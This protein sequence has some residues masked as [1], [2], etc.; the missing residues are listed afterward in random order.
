MLIV[1][2][3]CYGIVHQKFIPGIMHHEFVPEGQDCQHSFLHGGFEAS[4]GSCAA[5]FARGQQ[6]DPSPG[7]C[8]FTHCLDS[9]RVFGSQLNHC[10][11]PPSLLAEFS[12]LRFF[13][14]SKVQVDAAWAASG[15]CGNDYSQ[16]GNVAQ[17][18]EGRRLSRV[19]QPMETE[20]GQ[21][22]CI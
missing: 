9:V 12:S 14:V 20:V 13:L 4:E 17:R 7:Q 8:P 16:I 18:L 5:K 22:H 15:G 10:D 11:G 19:L 1:F 21:V 3:D 6:L 2:F